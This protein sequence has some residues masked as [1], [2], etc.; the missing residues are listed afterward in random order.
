MKKKL[1][2]LLSFVLVLSAFALTACPEDDPGNQTDPGDTTQPGANAKA[3]IAT[4]IITGP[5]GDELLKKEFTYYSS[6][7]NVLEFTKEVCEDNEFNIKVDDTSVERL[8]EY[9]NFSGDYPKFFWD[10]LV[11]GA[12]V[13]VG[14]A[15]NTPVAEGDVIE[16][17]F[18]ELK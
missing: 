15:S 9:S 14:N 10:F 2:L 12:P 3:I 13:E 8:G 4:L 18:V 6:N 5:K 7:P 1:M 11:N 16:W 17:I